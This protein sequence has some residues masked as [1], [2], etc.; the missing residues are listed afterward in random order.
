MRINQVKLMLPCIL[1]N[2]E[3]LTYG[4]EM[5]TEQQRVI[6]CEGRKQSFNSSIKAEIETHETRAHEIGNKLT[7]G[8]EYRDVEC[9]IERDWETKVRRWVR[10]DTGEIAKEDIIPEYELQEEMELQDKK[11]QEEQKSAIEIAAE[12]IDGVVKDTLKSN[13]VHFEKCKRKK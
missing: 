3:K 9:K 13:T 7:S 6:E 8:K 5:A 4:L 11:N 12:I 10:L 1:S 2:D